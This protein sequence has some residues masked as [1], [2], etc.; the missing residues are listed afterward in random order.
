VDVAG[1]DIQSLHPLG[2]ESKRTVTRKDLLVPEL[3]ANNLRGLI[4]VIDLKTYWEA[5]KHVWREQIRIV[6]WVVMVFRWLFHGGTY[7]DNDTETPLPNYI[8]TEA[9]KQNMPRLDI[10]VSVLFSK[11]D[12]FNINPFK[13]PGSEHIL[14]PN[15]DLPFVIAR[16]YLPSLH[17]AL[18]RDAKNFRYDFIQSIVKN[19]KNEVVAKQSFGVEPSLKWLLEPQSSSRLPTRYLIKLHDFLHFF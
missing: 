16:D 14:S 11:V 7:P 10:P 5:Q 19:D 3:I 2:G 18:L 6:N 8:Q 9:T 1:E 17:K 13:V 12:D 15:T 4:L